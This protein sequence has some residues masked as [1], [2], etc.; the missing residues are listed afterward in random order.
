M[1]QLDQILGDE[2][3]GFLQTVNH[4]FADTLSKTREER[5]LERLQA[6]GLQGDAVQQVNLKAIAA[7]AHLSNEDQAVNDIHYILKA[8][9][10]VAIKTGFQICNANAGDRD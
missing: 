2:R 3:G 1:G 10:Q 4:Y 5:V 6:L 9:Y 8:C 7:A